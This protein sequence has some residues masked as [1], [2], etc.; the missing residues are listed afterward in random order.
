MIPNWADGALITPVAPEANALRAE[1]GLTGAFVVG[2]SG[3][4]GRAHEY[5]TILDA[6]ARLEAAPAPPDGQRVVWLLIGGGALYRQF[7]AEAGRRGLASVRFAPYQPRERLAESLSASDVHLVS[8]RPDMEGLVVPSK[9]YGIAAAG[10]PA[11]FIGDGDGEIAR[12]LARH[13][14]GFTVAAGDGAALAA[15]VA[16]LAAHPGEAARMG[17][18]A[19]AAFEAEFSR[20]RAV[21][22]WAALLGD[23]GRS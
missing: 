15:V 18:A 9:Y 4:L 13:G 1:W 10:R 5:E 17:H 8:L 16:R 23:V 19:R 2:Y 7:E 11:I 22:R 20:D 6:I 14:T 3:N 21:A 12:S